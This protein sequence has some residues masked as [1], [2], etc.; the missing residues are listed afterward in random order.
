MVDCNDCLG[1]DRL[2]K[3]DISTQDVLETQQFGCLSILTDETTGAVGGGASVVDD[4]NQLKTY[5]SFQDVIADWDANSAVYKAARETFAQTP[6]VQK[7]NVIFVDYTNDIPT[8]LD[9]RLGCG[10]C[11]G[12]ITPTLTA[13]NEATVGMAVSNWVESDE[14]KRFIYVIQTDDEDSKDRTVRTTIMALV[15]EAGHTHTTVLYHPLPNERFDAAFLS[16]GLGQDLDAIGSDFTMA[17]QKLTGLTP[18][19]LTDTEVTNITGFLPGA[20]CSASTGNFGSV[21]TCINNVNVVYLG[22]MSDGNF[23]DTLLLS[24]YIKARVQEAVATIVIRGEVS[25]NFAGYTLISSTIASVLKRFQENGWIS[26]DTIP[27]G[28]RGFIIFMPN[29]DETSQADAKCR[30]I[31]DFKFE[32]KLL[33]RAHYVGVVGELTF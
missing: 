33:G 21:Y 12:L 22:A 17:Y 28:Q 2:V 25:Q 11:T 29:P 19:K 16:F 14:K 31:P 30:T 4:T 8:Q 18:T 23:F 26:G 1:L 9:E 15:Q 10:D 7:I 3:V 24:K 5:T 20:G 6:K 32:A 13:A 27:G